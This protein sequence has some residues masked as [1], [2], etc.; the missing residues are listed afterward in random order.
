M[1]LYTGLKPAGSVIDPDTFNSAMKDKQGPLPAAAAQ[2]VTDASKLTPA[3]IAQDKV[4]EW[5]FVACQSK[6]MQTSATPFSSAYYKLALAFLI[7]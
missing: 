3:Q 5:S 7:A 6:R 1:L 2:S 4:R